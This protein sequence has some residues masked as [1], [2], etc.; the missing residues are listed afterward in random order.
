MAEEVKKEQ[1]Q[2]KQGKKLWSKIMDAVLGVLVVLLLALQIDI[3]I[4]SRQNYGVPSLFGYSFMQIL[5]NSMDGPEDDCVLLT[6]QKPVYGV[7]SVEVDPLTETRPVLEVFPLNYAEMETIKTNFDYGYLK[8]RGPK[9]LHVNT[10]IIIRHIEW[11]D[12]MPGDVLTFVTDITIN[13][14]VYRA[15]P[16]SHRVI[17]IDH[18]K[19]TLSCFGDNN[20]PYDGSR[21]AFYSDDT[22]RNDLKKEAIIGEVISNNDALGVVLGAVQSTWFLPVMILIPLGIIGISSAV[23]AILKGHRERKAEKLALEAAIDAA[24]ID[25]NDEVAMETFITRYQAKREMQLELEQEKAR[26]KEIYRQVYQEEKKRLQAENASAKG[27]EDIDPFEKIKQEEKARL[28]AELLAGKNK[29]ETDEKA[30][31]MAKIKEEEKAKLKAQMAK[32]AA[33]AD[34]KAAL[35]EKIK[36]EEKAKLKAEMAKQAEQDEKAALMAKIKEEEKAK[37]RAQ[38]LA[39]QGAKDGK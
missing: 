21:V 26:Q 7:P 5:T 14:Q 34:E 27:G 36:A 29:E 16:T 35:M 39:E 11:E 30:A 32:E 24:G 31:L 17:E 13:G 20:M 2:P 10:G 22:Q 23:D 12:V 25:R 19:G 3:I 1:E 33:P 4:T 15:Q 8:K 9:F 38:L 18:A 28:R 37:L 6:Y